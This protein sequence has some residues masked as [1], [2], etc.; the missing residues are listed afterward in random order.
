MAFT[1]DIVERAWNLSKSQC[2][3]ERSFHNHGDRCPQ[4]L[5]KEDRGIHEKW[6]ASS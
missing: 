6:M 3:C 1:K 4:N 5:V 2:Q